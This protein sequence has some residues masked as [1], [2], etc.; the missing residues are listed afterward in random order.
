MKTLD[1]ID[2]MIKFLE[3]R[4]MMLKALRPWV[5]NMKDDEDAT[6]AMS[7]IIMGFP[8]APGGPGHPD[9]IRFKETRL[10]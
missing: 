2:F 1:R 6:L 4:V 8:W 5:K 3:R 10:T 9:T 7:E